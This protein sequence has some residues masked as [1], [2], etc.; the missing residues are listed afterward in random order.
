MPERPEELFHFGEREARKLGAFHAPGAAARRTAV[1]LCS[2]FGHEVVRAH[3]AYRQ[4]ALR[5][6]VLG[7]PV[8]RF[9]LLGCG[10]SAGDETDA[11][12][13]RW[14]ADVEVAAAEALRRSGAE[15]I[16]LAGGRLGAALALAAAG[17]IERARRLV[18]WDPVADGGEYLAELEREHARML[19]T[20]HVTERA[21]PG[22]S[23]EGEILGFPLPASLRREIGEVRPGATVPTGLASV[24]IL[25]SAEQP[26]TGALAR[27]LAGEGIRVDRRPAEGEPPWTWVQD[28]ARAV[29]PRAA[30]ESIADWIDGE[31]P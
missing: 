2:P 4:L 16:C 5:L 30:I 27:R 19:A 18:L 3:R 6:A 21:A 14:T 8:L 11:S 9:D 24:L 12:L 13:A 25:E 26:G 10:D 28:P 15:G 20:A 22:D 7:F 17:R 23:G 1:V 31:C 29:L